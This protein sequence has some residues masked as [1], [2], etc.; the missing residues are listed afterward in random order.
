MNRNIL[1]ESNQQAAFSAAIIRV[2]L[3]Y[4]PGQNRFLDLIKGEI[5]R[6]SFDFGMQRNIRTGSSRLSPLFHQ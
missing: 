6:L 2:L 5:V 4:L 3:Q 1:G